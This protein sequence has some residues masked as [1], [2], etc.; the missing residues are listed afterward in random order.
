V[1][2][3]L[4]WFIVDAIAAGAFA[5]GPAN[6]AARA[7]AFRQSLHSVAGLEPKEKPLKFFPHCG[8]S[9]I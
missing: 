9:A 7:L 1:T 4:N 6:L 8:H 2:L 5:A 3:G